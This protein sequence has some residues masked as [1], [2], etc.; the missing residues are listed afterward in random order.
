MSNA[1]HQH[2]RGARP[3]L[4]GIPSSVLSF[5]PCPLILRLASIPAQSEVFVKTP[6]QD[7]RIDAHRA[8]FSPPRTQSLLSP[9]KKRKQTRS[10]CKNVP[11][12]DVSETKQDV[13]SDQLK[14]DQPWRFLLN[15]VASV[16]CTDRGSLLHIGG[17]KCLTRGSLNL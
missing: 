9:T 5:S 17:G 14:G 10:P 3:P 7:G 16:A 4:T 15:P 8:A 2:V 13:G 1:T 11:A 12:S 6:S